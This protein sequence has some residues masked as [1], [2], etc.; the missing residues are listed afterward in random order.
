MLEFFQST[1]PPKVQFFALTGSIVLLLVV[2]NLIQREKLKEGYSIIWFIVGIILVIVSLVTRLLDIMAR[3]VGV[4]NSPTAL[5]LILL[6]GLVLLS[7]HFSVLVSKHDRQIRDLAQENAILRE[8]M[9]RKL[10]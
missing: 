8:S 4:S 10:K 5:F 2:V 7:L 6:V 9:E 1:I 3:A